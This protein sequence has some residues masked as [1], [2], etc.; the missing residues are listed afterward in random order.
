MNATTETAP[1]G[2]QPIETI[3]LAMPNQVALNTDAQ[4]SLDM[5][6][7]WEIDSPEMYELAAAE[8]KDIKA[9]MSRLEEQRKAITKPLDDARSNCSPWP[10]RNSSSAW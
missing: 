10:S 5:A 4:A 3:R 2:N 8:L 1:T 6:E 9:R 7:A